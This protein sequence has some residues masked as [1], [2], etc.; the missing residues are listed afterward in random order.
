MQVSS[1]VAWDV[2]AA[3]VGSGSQPPIRNIPGERGPQED[4]AG[5]A[6]LVLYVVELARG[7]A[8]TLIRGSNRKA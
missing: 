1:W 7:T 2:H 4:S 5:R 3:C 6:F 8:A